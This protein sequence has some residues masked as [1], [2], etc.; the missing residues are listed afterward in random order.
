MKEGG[1]GGMCLVVLRS[2]ADVWSLYL[3]VDNAT[4][5]VIVAGKPMAGCFYRLPVFVAAMR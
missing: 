4:S 5:F 2:T 3:F 1:E